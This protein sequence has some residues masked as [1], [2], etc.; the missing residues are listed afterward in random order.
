M[1][2]EIVEIKEKTLV[3]FKTR[4][5]DDETMSEK[6]S[7]LW[8]KLYSEKGAKNIEN[9]D[10]ISSAK[11]ITLK[12]DEKILNNSNKTIYTSG[13]LSISGKEIENKK[14]AEFLATD[15][16]LKADKVKNEVGTIKASNNIIIKADKFE[17]I[18]EVKDLDR[19]ESYYETWDG[20]VLT[21]SEIGNW[22]KIG[23]NYSEKKRKAC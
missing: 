14:N 20:K 3:G 23:G 7:D 10:L 12:A 5:K 4:V 8:K 6:I 9:N 15:I 21:E 18:G 17:N 2:Y 13:K 22:K 11:N 19:Y 16:E 1:K